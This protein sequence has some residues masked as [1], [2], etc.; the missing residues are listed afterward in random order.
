MSK[1]IIALLTPY[2]KHL[3][4]PEQRKKSFGTFAGACINERYSGNYHFNGELF[5]NIYPQI[6]DA[7]LFEKV[8]DK[9]LSNK[10]GKKSENI[11][12]LLK[13]NGICV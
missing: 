13:D 5:A 10:Y 12:Y 8:R 1:Y 9:V 11:T 3:A 7:E 6:I 4:K 2:F